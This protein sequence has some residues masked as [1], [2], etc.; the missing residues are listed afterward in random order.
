MR[1]HLIQVEGQADATLRFG[2]QFLE[3]ALA[4]PTGVDLRLHDIERP[5]QLLGGFDG[6]IDR[7]SG[8]T[9]GDRRAIFRQQFLR[10]IFV[11]V[12]GPG[13]SFRLKS[14]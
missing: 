12:H 4:A 1:L 14:C 9:G 5:G 3:L 11:N 13:P 2:G 8:V 7:E 6:F 10:L